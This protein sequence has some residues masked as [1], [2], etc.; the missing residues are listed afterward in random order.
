MKQRLIKSAESGFT[1]LEIVVA[2]VLLGILTTI[3][4]FSFEGSKS[5]GQLLV[6]GMDEY[7]NALIR[8]KADTAC[9]PKTLNALFVKT[10]AASSSC[11]ISLVEQ[12]NGPYTKDA[13]SDGN[14]DI[15]LDQLAP[16]IVL[17]IESTAV[18]GGSQWY[19][20]AAGVPNE[21]LTQSLIACNGSDKGPGRCAGSPGSGGVKTGK[22]MLKFSETR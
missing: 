10:A 9:Y 12:W 3:A 18:G 7:G 16:G 5:R 14:G 19:V 1:L 15:L 11:E 8:M 17:S 22:L 21:I 6:S 2:I 13:R 4:V 20:S